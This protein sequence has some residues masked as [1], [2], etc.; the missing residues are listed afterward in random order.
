M[1]YPCSEPPGEVS[2]GRI[3]LP[4]VKDCPLLGENLPLIVVSH[5]K[6]GSFIGHHD[7]DEMLADAGFIVASINHPGDNFSDP[8]RSDELSIYVERPT[9][10][11]V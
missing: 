7:T 10:S 6:R 11:S 9:T 4:G 1:W 8:S 3:T 5:G 2:L